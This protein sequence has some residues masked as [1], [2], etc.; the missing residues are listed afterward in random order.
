MSDRGFNAVSLGHRL[1]GRPGADPGKGPRPV[2]PGPAD[3]SLLRSVHS[4]RLNMYSQ[5]LHET[6]WAWA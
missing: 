4:Q 2:S 5:T 1:I 3:A 6:G